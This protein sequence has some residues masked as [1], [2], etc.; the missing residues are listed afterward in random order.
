MSRKFIP[1]LMLV[2][3]VACGP[4]SREIPAAP[5]AGSGTGFVLASS[6]FSDNGRIPGGLTCDAGNGSPALNWSGAPSGTKS[7]IL[8]LRD[9]D[10]PG[11]DFLHW[12]VADI[13]PSVSGVGQNDKFPPGSRALKNSADVFGY[14]GPCPPS[15]THRYIFSLYATDAANFGG[16]AAQLENFLKAH[17]LAKAVLTGLYKRK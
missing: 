17:T 8:T 13:P 7:F 9:P 5:S 3:L 6:D 2:F 10:A 12:A 14:T 1:V 4:Q 16:E 15:G 11:G